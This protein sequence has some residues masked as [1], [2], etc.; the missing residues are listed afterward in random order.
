MLDNVSK[1][2]G[3]RS[4]PR[5]VRRPPRPAE[6]GRHQAAVIAVSYVATDLGKVGLATETH[7]LLPCP[8]EQAA[9]IAQLVEQRIENSRVTSSSLVLGNKVD[10][11]L[12][13][14]LDGPLGPPRKGVE[15]RL[16][17]GHAR[18]GKPN[19]FHLEASS[20]AQASDRPP[21]L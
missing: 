7:L 4:T 10:K 15:G 5:G 12:R 6:G 1:S 19:P 17:P 2:G 3:L 8:A 20:D 9:E 14:S 18:L 13:S 21:R 11:H 16:Q